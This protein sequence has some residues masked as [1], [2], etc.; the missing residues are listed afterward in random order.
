MAK[1]RVPRP[2]W[3]IRVRRIN[4]PCLAWG[5]RSPPKGMRRPYNPQGSYDPSP[6]AQRTPGAALR[7]RHGT[8][9]M[10]QVA[11][12][13]TST[14]PRG[15][16]LPGWC[17]ALAGPGRSGFYSAAPCRQL[18]DKPRIRVRSLAGLASTC[19]HQPQPRLP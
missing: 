2:K 17:P 5:P 18:L 9:S 3:R 11:S 10:A 6:G 12:S 15:L 16:A 4:D 19:G 8:T 1:G 7:H 13:R 14:K